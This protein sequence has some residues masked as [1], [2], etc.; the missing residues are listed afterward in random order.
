[1][2]VLTTRGSAARPHSAAHT[3][4]AWCFASGAVGFLRLGPTPRSPTTRIQVPGVHKACCYGRVFTPLHTTSLFLHSWDSSPQHVE[5]PQVPAT[6]HSARAEHP[7][8]CWV[9]PPLF[10]LPGEE[11]SS[12]FSGPGP[13]SSLHVHHPGHS[14]RT[15]QSM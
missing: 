5:E 13:A 9:P 14:K 7:G 3:R 11:P 15:K 6:R 1:M 2:P 8:P 4:E 12:W 10:L